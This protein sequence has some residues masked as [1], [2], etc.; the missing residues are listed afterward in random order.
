[1]TRIRESEPSYTAKGNVKHSLFGRQSDSLN[2]PYDP[3]VPFLGIYPREMNAYVHAKNLYVNACSS[4]IENNQ[5]VE[6]T[7]MYT[8]C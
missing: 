8:K 3:A 1:M 2:T 4:V 6:T 5:R 7:P